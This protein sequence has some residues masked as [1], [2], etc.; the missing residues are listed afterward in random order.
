[1]ART[2][3]PMFKRLALECGGK[4]ATV[5]F[6]DADLDAAIA[7]SVRAAFAN[8]GEICLAGSRIFVERAVYDRLADC[9]I[10]RTRQLKVGDP[11]EEGT[12]LGAVISQEHRAKIE[13][14][15]ALAKEE[16]GQIR[17]G[18]SRAAAPNDRCRRG[19]FVEP[20]VITGL[21][22]R[23]RTN[24]EE[25]FGPVVTIAP[26][27]GEQEATAFANA[28]PYGLAASLWTTNLDRAHRVAGQ[29]QS[30]TV[31]VNCWLLRDLRVPFGGM[32]QSGLGR[33]GG[34]EALRF[35][36]EPKNVCIK[37]RDEGR[38]TRDE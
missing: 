20:T 27:D 17:C 26:F 28:T 35:F 34:E 4:N 33:E 31:W 6:A 1:I 29:I 16:G 22:A 25:I 24:T 15:L 2:A 8:Q 13:S 38:G 11:L 9:Y 30:G 7:T 12:D 23:C 10:E 5:I 21:D 3:A 19:F 14:Y 37:L 18:G 36:T 32:K